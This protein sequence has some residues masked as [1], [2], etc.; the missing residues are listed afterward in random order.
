[1]QIQLD[2]RNIMVESEIPLA[3]G[4]FSSAFS[5][6]AGFS[7]ALASFSPNSNGIF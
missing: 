1:M 3:T 2:N 6:A 7:S 5:W 4:F